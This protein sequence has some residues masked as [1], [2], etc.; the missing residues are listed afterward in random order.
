VVLAVVQQ[1]VQMVVLARRIKALLAVI[2]LLLVVALVE[3]EQVL[4]V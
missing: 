2:A 1:K 4:L 3:V